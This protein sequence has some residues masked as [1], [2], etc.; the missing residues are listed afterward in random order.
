MARPGCLLA[1]LLASC[2]SGPWYRQLGFGTEAETGRPDA[3]PRLIQGLSSSDL[4]VM[5]E[6][7]RALARLGEPAVHALASEVRD[8]QSTAAAWALG[9]M[10]A[11]A[12]PGVPALADALG[13]GRKHLR[14]AAAQ[15]L[16]KLGQTAAPALPALVRALAADPEDDV[17]REVPPALAKIGKP[18]PEVM[19][20]LEQ[21]GA[22]DSGHRVRVAARRAHQALRFAPPPPKIEPKKTPAPIVALF[23]LQDAAG[24]LGAQSVE[25]LTEYL[26]ARLAAGGFRVIPRDQ[27]RA[28]LVQEKTK[29]YRACFDQSCQIELGRA[30]A[31][32][33]SVAC[34]LLRLGSGEGSPARGGGTPEARGA[35]KVQC[36]LTALI[37]D[38]RSEATERAATVETGCTDPQ[39]LEG[40]RKLA[41]QLAPRDR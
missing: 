16:A 21:A 3:I 40:L 4:D 13:S 14:K 34:K 38:L 8:R 30:L 15:A 7:S 33:K 32:Q 39:L 26:A 36:A 23:D 10:G 20:V 29:S 1:L 2:A 12:A 11:A 41:E 37:F 5:R 25:Q 22:H 9:E 19:A 35:P 24:E 6:S 27:L 18:S 17:R 31:A 28:R